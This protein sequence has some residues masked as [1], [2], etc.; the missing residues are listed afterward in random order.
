MSIN[1]IPAD[2]FIRKY[3]LRAKNLMWF[4]GAGT[5]ASAGVPTALDMIWDFK[6]QLYASQRRVSRQ[7]VADLSSSAIRNQLQAHVDSLGNL[8]PPGAPGEYAAL[9]EAVYPDE[10]DRRTYID[11]KITGAKPS[12]GHLALSTL[13]R[14]GL[15]RV[16]WTT[17]F[18]P[19]V[20]DAC[21][22]IFGG[23]GS[24]TTVTLDSPDVGSSALNEGRW[25][26]EVKLHGDFRSRRLKN[27]NDE[28]RTQDAQMRQHLLDSCR[29]YGL[30]VAGYSG[31]D[32]SVMDSLEEVLATGTPYPAGLFWL[33]RGEDEPSSRVSQ[34][35]A[36][37]Q[38]RGI[39][40]ALIKIETFDELMRDLIRVVEGLDSAQL[41]IFG[42]ERNRWTAA[43]IP[44]GRK[45][46][47]IVR[48]NALAISAAPT[49]CRRVACTIGGHAEIRKAVEEAR[50][51]IAFARRQVGVLAFGADSDV[52]KVFSQY[53][54][55]EFDLHPLEKRRLRYESS[56]RGLLRDAL[57]RAFI[58]CRKLQGVHRRTTDLLA[59]ANCEDAGWQELRQLTGS[60]E[61]T[62]ANFPKLRWREGVGVRLD[63]AADR[64]WLLVEPRLMFDGLDDANRSA[65]TD[66][67]RERSIKR[68]NKQ[69]NELL[70]FW[71][72][73]LAG[74]DLRAFGIGDG[75]DAVFE[76]SSTSAYSM[77]AGA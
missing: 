63:W 11:G 72:S 15:L 49:I 73:T 51:D 19:L 43:P 68:Y 24:L 22:K 13:M 67:A 62:V 30:V 56:E 42:T 52:R 28:L 27:T 9:F 1:S 38:D 45:G 14:A 66:F 48:L 33:H 4:V 46:W 74:D 58:R 55:R 34:L 60:I 31:R 29:R 7:V 32:E 37:V 25:P 53:E 8:P 10:R 5:S 59:P 70:N 61:G 41:D 40:C 64:L 47:P 54:I 18:D 3:S 12:Y 39:E 44:T 69:L 16:I 2:E 35:L 20:A 77:R 50:V 76:I 71:A 23:T 6:Q 57:R 65:A 17:N 26:I 36:K 75:V 21:A